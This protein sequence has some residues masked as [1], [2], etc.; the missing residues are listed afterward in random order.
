[1]QC[2]NAEL[3]AAL[4]AQCD[5]E[6]LRWKDVDERE[7]VRGMRDRERGGRGREQSGG[8]RGYTRKEDM[9][10]SMKS[11]RGGRDGECMREEG[12]MYG[13]E[14]GNGERQGGDERT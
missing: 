2:E 14:K 7:Y 8:V 6:R 4:D 3:D 12:R 9:G 13:G 10:G 11:E 1:V 5:S